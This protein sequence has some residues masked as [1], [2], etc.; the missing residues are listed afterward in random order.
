[1]LCLGRS[2][3]IDPMN[4]LHATVRN[5]GYLSMEV[6]IDGFDI[7]MALS[8]S[9]HSTSLERLE[10]YKA[11]EHGLNEKMLQKLKRIAA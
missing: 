7:V 10:K 11:V 6:N 5:D 8:L 3:T 1:M 9:Y 4:A 2:H